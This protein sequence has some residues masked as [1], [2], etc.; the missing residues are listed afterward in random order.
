MEPFRETYPTNLM[1]SFILRSRR[2][3]NTVDATNSR[4]VNY[5]QNDGPLLTTQVATAM[6]MNPTPSRLYREN[7][8]RTQPYIPPSQTLDSIQ[9]LS[10]LNTDITNTLNTIQRLQ[11]INPQTSSVKLQLKEQSILYNS[12]VIR[13]KNLTTD[14]LSSNPYFEKYDAAGDSRNV[15]RELRGVVSEGVVDR[16]TA[17]SQ[18]LL[19][20]SLE[21]RWVSAEGTAARWASEADTR[22]AKEEKV[23]QAALSAFELLR[24]RF[25][26]MDKVYNN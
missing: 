14:S 6:D 23:D 21:S 9:A 25:N 22:R 1:P 5:W 24:P 4:F 18:K 8:N 19:Q 15:I 13:K 26:Q 16:G 11:Q 7:L 3:Q 2:E 20:R 12:L 17:E 10:Q